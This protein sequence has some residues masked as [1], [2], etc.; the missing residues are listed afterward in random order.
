MASHFHCVDPDVCARQIVSAISKVSVSLPSQSVSF[1]SHLTDIFQWAKEACQFLQ[2]DY[3]TSI[4]SLSLIQRLIYSDAIPNNQLHRFAT[5]ALLV[6]IKQSGE[7][8]D[9]TTLDFLCSLAGNHFD[10]VSL[11]QSE[12]GL[13]ELFDWNISTINSATFVLLF[14][15][16]LCGKGL[17]SSTQA[18]HII[19]SSLMVCLDHFIGSNNYVNPVMSAFTA[20]TTMCEQFHVYNAYTILSEHVDVDTEHYLIELASVKPVFP[21]EEQQVRLE[22]YCRTNTPPSLAAYLAMRYNDVLDVTSS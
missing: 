11:K 7:V 16:L 14:S 18:L 20:V 3:W 2:L 6:A 15:Q 4:Q 1:P 12:V 10:A 22:K 9:V 5:A 13:L 17:C 8:V 19:D 21:E